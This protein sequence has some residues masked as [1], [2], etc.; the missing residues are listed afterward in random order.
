MAFNGSGVFNRVHSW[1]TDKTN[2][3]PVTASRMDAEDDG[4]ATGLSNTICRD[5]QSTT[6]ARIPF[7]SGV[8]APAGSIASVSY[9]QTNDL[10]T[11]L[12]FPAT[13]QW[14]MVAGGVAT[15]TSTATKLTAPVAVDFSGTAAPTASD[16]AALGST[17]K[18][19]SDLFLAS[20][21]VINWNAGDIAVTGNVNQLQFEGAASGYLFDATVRP[22]VNDIGALGTATISWSDL[23]LASGGVINWNNSNVTLT[24]SVGALAL[25]G[26]LTVSSTLGVTGA[27]TCSSTVTANGG[28][29]TT[30]ISASSTLAVTGAA[31][32]SSTLAVTGLITGRIALL[33]VRDEKADTTAGGTASGST[34]NTRTLNTAVTNEISGASLAS[35]QITL[36]AGTYEIDASAPQWGSGHGKLRL[37]NIT[38]GSDAIIGQNEADGD[39]TAGVCCHLRG[40]FTI[41]GAKV[42]ELHHWTQNGQVTEGLG[43][44]VS[45][46][47]T[48][49]YAEVL[50]WK[51]G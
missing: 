50:I 23:F 5:G 22:T 45:A 32:L 17:T 25:A 38:D 30:A 3:V 43:R 35:N 9:A 28:V 11:G 18:M 2:T 1:A 33:H 41:A 49:V 6:T 40:R 14:G 29:S 24:H 51:V 39:A 16:G 47:V 19:W 48:E 46:G 44:A 13:D 37:R 34:W 10:N 27:L 31:T 42:F 21:G 15:L 20:G 36:P 7:A 26:A 4:F 8:S 12:Y